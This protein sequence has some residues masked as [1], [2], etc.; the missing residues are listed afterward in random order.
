M[1]IITKMRK[2]MCVYWPLPVNDGYGGYTW[3]EAEEMTCRWETVRQ[4]MKDDKGEDFVSTATV[5]VGED[6]TIGGYLWLGQL[7]D[8]PY[9]H[10][11]P[12]AS[13]ITGALKIKS[14]GKSP[15]LKATEY[16]RTVY[17]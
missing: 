7:D 13:T 3:G 4:I 16:L 8:L 9:I 10:A 17:L 15:N 1:S 14:V 5:Y 12:L 11:N 2:Q 6:L